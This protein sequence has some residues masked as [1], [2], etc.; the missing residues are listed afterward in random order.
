[1]I[2]FFKRKASVGGVLNISFILHGD[3]IVCGPEDAIRTFITSD[4]D[5]MQ[6]EQYYVERA[7]DQ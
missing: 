1:M 6:L 2:K 3:P 4:L 5:A 7:R